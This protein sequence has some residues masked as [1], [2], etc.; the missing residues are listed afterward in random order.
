MTW[1][2]VDDKLHAHRKARRVRRGVDG[3][4]NDIAPMGLWVMAGSWAGANDTG[5]WVPL[6]E[7][8]EWDDDAIDLARR[9]VAS[10]LF[11][12]ETR[13]GEPGFTFHDWADMNPMDSSESGSFGN[14]QRWHVKRG[15]VKDDCP[16]CVPVASPPIRDRI[17]PE[18]LS[19]PDPTRPDI[20]TSVDSGDDLAS[21]RAAKKAADAAE[22]DEW[23]AIYPKKVARGAAVRAYASARKKADQPVLVA[24]ARSF[25]ILREGQDH[26]FT[27]NPSTW[28]NQE[29]W[30]DVPPPPKRAAYSPEDEW[31]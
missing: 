10:G 25:A 13:D 11:H 29:R 27:P 22:F 2:K 15:K 28:L 30:N 19:R 8:L 14:H 6:E 1:F 26:K 5:G 12:P 7:L 21:K 18:S 20:H 24:A 4:S 31:S 3:K 23:Y 9:L 16:H 17:A